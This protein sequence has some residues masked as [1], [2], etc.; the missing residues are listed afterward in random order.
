[1]TPST[2]DSHTKRGRDDA[3]VPSV[4]AEGLMREGTKRVRPNTAEN[5]TLS[6][7]QSPGITQQ[8]EVASLAV[9]GRVALRF[10]TSDAASL[11]QEDPLINSVGIR[12][13]VYP[14]IWSFLLDSTCDRARL[15]GFN[16]VRAMDFKSIRSFMLVNKTS[17]EAFDDCRGWWMC[18]QA[19]RREAAAKRSFIRRYKKRALGRGRDLFY[20]TNFRNVVSLARSCD[21]RIL[22]INTVLLSKASRLA[23]SYGSDEVSVD[24]YASSEEYFARLKHQARW[25]YKIDRREEREEWLRYAYNVQG[26]LV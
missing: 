19:L 7:F 10:A 15:L 22:F 11:I 16:G 20:E 17:K 3:H 21:S 1:M 9:V 24:P 14:L 4:F 5:E 25:I 26:E 23:V 8:Q 13:A 12:D 6:L 18:A 2:T